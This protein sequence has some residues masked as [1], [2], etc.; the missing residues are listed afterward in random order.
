[1]SGENEF[2]N[3]FKY[4]YYVVFILHHQEKYI[5]DTKILRV[6]DIYWWIILIVLKKNTNVSLLSY[7]AKERC[8]PFSLLDM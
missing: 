5:Y 1:M 7:E 2:K 3:S 4:L 8:K 6:L